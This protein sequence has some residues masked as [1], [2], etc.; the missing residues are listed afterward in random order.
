MFLWMNSELEKVVLPNVVEIGD[1]CLSNN[2][3]LQRIVCP[4]L[5]SYGEKFCQACN[6]LVYVYTPL[7]PELEAELYSRSTI[8]EKK[9]C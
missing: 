3:K 7:L 8:E 2:E 1:D 6:H 5:K 4:K 9:L